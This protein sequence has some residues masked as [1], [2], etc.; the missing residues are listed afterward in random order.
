[1]RSTNKLL[2]IFLASMMVMGAGIALISFSEESEAA[3]INVTQG[4]FNYS[5]DDVTFSASVL[6][7]VSTSIVTANIPSTISYGGQT[8]TIHSIGN[9]A[10]QQCTNL[11]SIT[12]PEGVKVLYDYAFNLCTGLTSV[13]LPSTITTMGTNAFGGCTSMTSLIISEGVTTISTTSA[14]S[15]CTG[16]TSVTLPSTLKTIGSYMFSGCKALTSITIPEG[17]TSI[18]A[19]AFSGSGL[20]SIT[21]PNTLTSIDN[22][23]FQNCTSLTA[24]TYPISATI[25]NIA[26]DKCTSLNEVTLTAG[27]GVGINYS[28]TG[29][30]N[31]PWYTNRTNPVMSITISEGVT[32]IGNY[33]F[34]NCTK[35]TSLTLPSTLKTI[36]ECT[37]QGCTNLTSLTIPEGVTSIGVSA[38]RMCTNL[39]SLT[40]PEGVTSIGNSAFY[41][42][43]KLTSV[44]LPSTLKT[45]GQDTFRD[46]TSLTSVIL[47]E[48]MT[49]TGNSTFSG[50]TGLTSVTLPS[51]LKIIGS[52]AFL[53][54]KN[55]TS[56]TIPEGVTSLGSSA[57]NGCI[58]VTSITTPI[59]LSLANQFPGC[60]NIN[61]IIFTPG[62]GVGANYGSTYATTPWYVNRNI[63][64]G[65]SV[66]IPEGVTSISTNMFRG[67]TSLTS[68]VIPDTVKTVDYN[69]FYDA[70]QTTL[71]I[72]PGT[73]MTGTVLSY[74]T[75]ITFQ[76]LQ[77]TSTPIDR[78]ISGTIW[79]YMPS[80]SAAGYSLSLQTDAPFL[81]LSGNTI[82]GIPSMPS[83]QS[84]EYTI[85][86]SASKSGYITT[87]QTFTLTVYREL[88]FTTVPTTI[89]TV[90]PLGNGVYLFDA[91]NS[92]DYTSLTWNFGDGKV[93]NALT[94]VHTF[95]HGVYDV[96]LSASNNKGISSATSR[97]IYADETIPDTARF[98]QPYSV[99]IPTTVIGT[100]TLFGCPWLSIT[101]YGSD[102]IVVSGTPLSTHYVDVLYNIILNTGS[103]TINWSVTVNRGLE[104]PVAGFTVTVDGMTVTIT[105]TAQ[106]AVRTWYVYTDGGNEFLT[107]TLITKHTYK[108]PGV[109]TITQIVRATI[110]NEEILDEYSWT[111]VIYAP[112]IDDGDGDVDDTEPEVEDRSKLYTAIAVILAVIFGG[113]AAAGY[114]SRGFTILAGVAIIVA[115]LIFFG[116]LII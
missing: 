36:G 2:G 23:A 107:N 52:S 39:T 4:N 31:T 97:V 49:T 40:I 94:V 92:S 61:E 100:P 43:T 88:T 17:V 68:L 57:F 12:I 87:I 79:S 102:Y 110:N 89:M 3:T 81:S 37:F 16:L 72:Y 1:M 19:S 59:S 96:S 7:P 5:L 69:A 64:G 9:R 14:F 42:C 77:I 70:G 11:T 13:T 78:A 32:S 113:L 62:T 54:C 53:S 85:T 45:I 111:I 74:I 75:V 15:N 66:T 103:D 28:S 84:Q 116:V 18:G 73:T 50:C 99:V 80:V 98:S 47:S 44:T 58:G 26:F 29:Y 22:Q 46:C 51:T 83:G 93:S 41:Q 112:I 27:T 35:L 106:N 33:A 6:G 109:Y 24:I 56:I 34:Y 30:G 114:A 65:L 95:T 90:T 108:E 10:F 104:W 48:G 101:D 38:F 115:A 91:S 21:L 82:S 20:T 105:S 86:I 25:G 71:Y 76:P 63:A 8:Y 60:T 55:L 67:C